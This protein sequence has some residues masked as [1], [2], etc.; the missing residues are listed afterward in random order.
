MSWFPDFIAHKLGVPLSFLLLFKSL[1]L[2]LVLKAGFHIVVS[3]RFKRVRRPWTTEKTV[4]KLNR[5]D[6][7]RPTTRVVS[8]SSPIELSSIRTT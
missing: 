8:A 5:D 7:E 2:V 1:M 3:G 4:W 6:R